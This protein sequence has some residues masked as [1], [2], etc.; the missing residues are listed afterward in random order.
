MELFRKQL[1]H[2]ASGIFEEE[3]PNQLCAKVNT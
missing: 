3:N 1:D 2:Q